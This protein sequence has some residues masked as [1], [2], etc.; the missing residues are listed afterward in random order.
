MQVTPFGMHAVVAGTAVAAQIEG[1]FLAP[2]AGVRYLAVGAVVRCRERPAAV[3]AVPAGD[4]FVG[5][6]V[7]ARCVGID[8]CST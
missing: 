4:E 5:G 2:P 3:V 6:T 7:R 1:E 8:G